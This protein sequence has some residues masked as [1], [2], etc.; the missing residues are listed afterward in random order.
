MSYTTEKAGTLLPQNCPELEQFIKAQ[1]HCR[2]ARN[3]LDDFSVHP[4][5]QLTEDQRR[6][7]K[8]ACDEE[9]NVIGEVIDA[10][11]VLQFLFFSPL[12]PIES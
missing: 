10:I 2:A 3:I 4:T 9:F 7:F 1:A 6:R 12:F 11:E 8:D 5:P